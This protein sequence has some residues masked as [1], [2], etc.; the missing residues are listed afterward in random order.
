MVFKQGSEALILH[1]NDKTI[2]VRAE[3]SRGKRQVNWLPILE[4]GKRK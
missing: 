3:T 4:A 1:W 2:L